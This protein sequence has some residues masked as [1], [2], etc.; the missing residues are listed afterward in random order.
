MN[1]SD[2]GTQQLA[3]KIEYLK[4]ENYLFKERFIRSPIPMWELELHDF[5]MLQGKRYFS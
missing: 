5:V 1:T 2:L 3:E 4:A